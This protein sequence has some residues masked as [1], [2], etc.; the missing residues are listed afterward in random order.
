MLSLGPSSCRELDGTH[1]G[2][3]QSAAPVEDLRPGIDPDMDP[4]HGGHLGRRPRGTSVAIQPSEEGDPVIPGDTP[5]LVI[6]E[7]RV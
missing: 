5:V 6:A 1:G 2:N 3:A 7:G 4:S